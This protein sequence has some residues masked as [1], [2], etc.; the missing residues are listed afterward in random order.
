MGSCFCFGSCVGSSLL[1]TCG[2]PDGGTGSSSRTGRQGPL[3]LRGRGARRA[4]PSP[5]PA[6]T[7]PEGGRLVRRAGGG[8]GRGV[9]T[10]PAGRFQ[11]PPPSLYISETQRRPVGCLPPCGRFG[12][13]C[14]SGSRAAFPPWIFGQIPKSATTRVFCPGRNF[15]TCI[16]F[17]AAGNFPPGGGFFSA[18]VFFLQVGDGCRCGGT[19]TPAVGDAGITGCRFAVGCWLARARPPAPPGTGC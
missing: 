3:A 7:P 1:Y 5:G 15:P 13:P 2:S 14:V 12:S 17:R 9:R 6:G 11:T 19:E 16:F 18:P 8:G 4:P 10:R